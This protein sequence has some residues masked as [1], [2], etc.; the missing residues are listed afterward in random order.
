MGQTKR[1]EFHQNFI[2]NYFREED[3]RFIA[4]T[5]A[6][7]VRVPFNYQLF[8]GREGFDIIDRLLVWAKR[9]SLDLVIDLHAAPGGQTGAN[10]DDSGGYPFLYQDSESVNLTIKIWR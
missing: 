8:L 9:Y 5:G 2:A 1:K 6:N 3:M 4:R 7:L 10:I